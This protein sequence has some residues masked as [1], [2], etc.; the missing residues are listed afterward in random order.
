MYF[1]H[2]CFLLTAIILG[3]EEVRG[4]A[5]ELPFQASIPALLEMEKKASLAVMILAGN[6]GR[7]LGWKGLDGGA[8]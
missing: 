5:L 3:S 1:M 2:T 8:S 7:C 6:G 4:T